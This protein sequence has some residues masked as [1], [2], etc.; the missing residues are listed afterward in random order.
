MFASQ[1]PSYNDQ[2][3]LGS[4]STTAVAN[5]NTQHP[6]YAQIA[7]L[8][9]LCQEYPALRRGRQ[10]VRAHGKTPGLFAV[11]R[12]ANDGR[13]L[14]IAFNTSTQAVVAQVEVDSNSRDF[15]TVRGPCPVRASAP[16]S[17][18]LKLLPLSYVVCAGEPR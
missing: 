13:E 16:G 8:A 6:M 18:S 12:M 14:L 1:V 11:S 2:K 17:A 10:V 7:G 15:K 3:L 9:K 4:S 5:F